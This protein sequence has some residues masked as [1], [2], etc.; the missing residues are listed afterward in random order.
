[1]AKKRMFNIEITESDKFIDMPASAQNLY[2]HLGLHGDDDGFVSAPKRIVRSIGSNET[3]LARLADEGY[4]IIFESGIIAITDWNI[5]NTLRNDRYK[6]TIY[7]EE[8]S[9]LSV[10]DAGRYIIDN[11]AETN[12]I[13]TDNQAETNGRRNITEQNLAK[14]NGTEDSVNADKPTRTRFSPPSVEEVREY[15]KERNNG[16][17]PEYFVDHYTA[18]G[19]MAGK[20]KM[21]DWKAA[22][23]KWERNGYDKSQNGDGHGK[24][25]GQNS[26]N[27]NEKKWNLPKEIVF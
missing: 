12:G 8:M 16:I 26:R 3:D 24:N 10:D 4:I 11:Q 2:F 6:P 27:S 23:R 21:K 7:T 25:H 14:Q 1:M 19:W 13:P 15:C 20:N 22:V 9:R 18:N 17:D 5:N